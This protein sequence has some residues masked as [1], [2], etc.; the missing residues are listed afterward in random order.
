MAAV[1]KSVRLVD[2]TIELCGVLSRGSEVNYSGSI[3]G[4]AQRYNVLIKAAMPD[5]SEG[6][7]LAICTAFNGYALADDVNQDIAGLDW[8]ISESM[9]YDGNFNDILAH[10]K[11]DAEELKAKI[12]GCNAAQRLAIID[13]TQRFWNVGQKVI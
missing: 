13:M 2:E 5:L 8:H 4:M 9:Q 1:K 12:R 6:E 3:N 11:I 10:H 7:R